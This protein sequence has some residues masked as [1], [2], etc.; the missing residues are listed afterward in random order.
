MTRRAGGVSGDN[1]DAG[2][3]HLKEYALGFD[4]RAA[5]ESWKGEK[6][7]HWRLKMRQGLK[8]EFIL[9]AFCG[10]TEVMPC[11]KARFDEVFAAA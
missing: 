11:Y 1:W 4:G 5:C 6:T 3:S 7:D 9:R 2:Q 8:P 10:T